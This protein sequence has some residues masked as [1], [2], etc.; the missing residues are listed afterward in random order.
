MMTFLPAPAAWT[1]FENASSETGALQNF[2]GGGLQNF[3]GLVN[4]PG[5]WTEGYFAPVFGDVDADGDTDLIVL[6]CIGGVR[7]LQFF[8]NVALAFDRVLENRVVLLADAQL[9]LDRVLENATVESTACQ[10]LRENEAST[11][12]IIDDIIRYGA[13]GEKKLAE[14]RAE[15][16]QEREALADINCTSTA[17]LQVYQT[18]L[19][20]AR[21]AVIAAEHNL[22]SLRQG[23]PPRACAM[24]GSL[25]RLVP[26]QCQLW[27]VRAY[28]SS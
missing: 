8:E 18:R 14:Y 11:Q 4:T 10:K 2:T 12:S 21:M 17:E 28:S 13:G 19:A 20:S 24:G 26:R 5:S 9:A 1:V 3:T 6:V 22:S 16:Q 23:H 7:R 15:L 25:E 27:R